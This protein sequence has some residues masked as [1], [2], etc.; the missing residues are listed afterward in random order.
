MLLHFPQDI[1]LLILQELVIQDILSLRSTCKSLFEAI[2]DRSVWL[3]VVQDIVSVLPLPLDYQRHLTTMPIDDLKRLA[4]R[5]AHLNAC[6]HLGDMSCRHLRESTCDLDSDAIY[7]LP[8]GDWLVGV[9]WRKSGSSMGLRSLN[10]SS[11]PIVVQ[12]PIP[13]AKGLHLL[14]YYLAF[15]DQRKPLLVLSIGEK[16]VKLSPSSDCY[17]R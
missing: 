1:F 10:T 5:E 2:E 6:W 14:E 4:L 8:G 13:E 16:F 7:L 11:S 9:I 15:S 12:I 3:Y 17:C